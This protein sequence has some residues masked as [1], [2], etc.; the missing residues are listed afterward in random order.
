MLLA[1]SGA[2]TYANNF[3]AHDE[4]PAGATEQKVGGN[5]IN[6]HNFRYR[7]RGTQKFVEADNVYTYKCGLQTLYFET[8]SGKFQFKDGGQEL[9][10]KVTEN[11]EVIELDPDKRK[12]SANDYPEK[13]FSLI[14]GKE[15]ETNGEKQVDAQ[16]GGLF[17]QKRDEFVKKYANK[18]RSIVQGK[19]EGDIELVLSRDYDEFLKYK[20]NSSMGYKLPQM[21]TLDGRIKV[22]GSFDEY[23]IATIF[24]TDKNGTQ[25]FVQA[26]KGRDNYQ[27]TVLLPGG[28]S[29]LPNIDISGGIKTLLEELIGDL[30]QITINQAKKE[31]NLAR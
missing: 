4:K 2:P 16:Y 19:E 18:F 10:F 9:R 22:K 26:E 23:Q 25:Y 5:I 11:D 30:A 15:T 8:D 29:V 28:S 6:E 21:E 17:R 3:I 31:Y 14:D 7:A 12:N 27:F 24:M 1:A 20:A 13:A